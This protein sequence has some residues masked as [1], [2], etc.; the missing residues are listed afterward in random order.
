MPFCQRLVA[1]V[2]PVSANAPIGARLALAC[3]VAVL[4]LSSA[5]RADPAIPSAPAGTGRQDTRPCERPADA[6]LPAPLAAFPALC[7]DAPS[8]LDPRLRADESTPDQ[9]A[10]APWGVLS[11]SWQS[12]TM[13]GDMGGLRPALAKYGLTLQLFEEAEIFGNLT[14][15]VRQSFEPNGV[16]TV[17]IQWDPKPL[18][19]LE[20]GLLNVSGF[21][22]WGGELSEA[23]L[24]NLQTISGLEAPASVRLWELWWQQK[25]GD[26][27]DVKIGEQSVDEEFMISQNSAYFANAAMGWPMLPSANLPASGPAYPLA[28]LGVRGRA[29]LSDTVAIMAGVFNGSPIPLN[30]PNTPRSNPNGV[31][32]PLDTGIFAIAELQVTVPAQDPSGKTSDQPAPWAT[33][34]LGAW[35]DSENF[36]DLQTDIF[37]APLASPE[38][39]GDPAKKQGN[40]AL[41]S[42]A[43]Q[44]LWRSADGNRSLNAFIRPMFT[45][46]QDRNEIAFSV[47]GGLTVRGPIAGRSGDTF[48]LGFGVARLSSGVAGY[49]RQMQVYEPDVFTPV[50][51]TETFFEATYQ[52]QALPSVQIQP[53]VQYVTNPG[54]GI[55]NPNW[56]T[57]TIKNEWV[58]GLRTN[59]TF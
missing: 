15:G 43:D 12:P 14:G 27:F 10:T 57:Q 9:A 23:N 35:Y 41:Y 6:A 11:G 38:S 39:D 22:I 40:F 46:L 16:T 7:A 55:P 44:T 31:S 36:S 8:A 19:G 20:G 54:G 2:A 4:C 50:R 30:A 56:P 26:R 49:D 18:L 24:L 25:F 58:L 59:I 51:S 1:W 34:K 13:L 33:Y 47:N 32:F 5:A 28:G 3:A 29:H 48:G 53:D 42:V 52:I 17:Q 21:H 37:G 45:T